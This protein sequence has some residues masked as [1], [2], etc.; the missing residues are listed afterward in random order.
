MRLFGLVVLFSLA[1]FTSFTHAQTLTKD[2]VKVFAEQQIYED[3][4]SSMH[5]GNLTRAIEL[6]ELLSQLEPQHAGGR[7]DLASVYCQLGRGNDAQSVLNKLKLDMPSIAD[8]VDALSAIVIGNCAN[9][10]PSSVIWSSYFEVASGTSS[11]VNLGS[12]QRDLIVG[13]VESPLLLT[14][15]SESMPRG[16]SFF[17]YKA[18]TYATRGSTDQISAT[19]AARELTSQSQFNEFITNLDWK[20]QLTSGSWQTITSADHKLT[21]INNSVYSKRVLIGADV[22]APYRLIGGRLFGGLDLSTTSYAQANAFNVRGT[23]SKA[24]I[25]WASGAQIEVGLRH[26]KATNNRPGGDSVGHQ[27]KGQ[28]ATDIA[29]GWRLGLHG[30]TQSMHDREIFFPVLFDIRRKQKTWSTIIRI[31]H[32]IAPSWISGLDYSSFAQ[33]DSIPIFS[34][35]GH[36]VRLWLRKKF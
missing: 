5:D 25:R 6:L 16:D 31:E 26:N 11:N 23:Y 2:S 7:L 17:D 29:P 15:P 33:N 9:K 30:Q 27:L 10:A 12:T 22:F 4:L 21:V 3:A 36:E 8:K 14:L 24:G 18:G 20:H 13:P 32:D 34:Y 1:S 28:Y 19:V 35:T